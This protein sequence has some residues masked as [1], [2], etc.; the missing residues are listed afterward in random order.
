MTVHE[1][2]ISFATPLR[3][4]TAGIAGIDSR[5]NHPCRPVQTM[6]S[7]LAV[8]FSQGKPGAKAMIQ[9]SRQKNAIVEIY[10]HTP[11]WGQVVCFDEMGPLQRIPRGGKAWRRHA[12]LRPD[13]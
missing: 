11:R 10:R 6:S 1:P 8:G 12:K 2:T 4:Q 5:S 9:N 3:G 13:R 7:Y